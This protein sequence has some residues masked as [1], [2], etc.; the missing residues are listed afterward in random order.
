MAALALL[1]WCCHLGNAAGC[2]P[3]LR[4]LAFAMGAKRI[5]SSTLTAIMAALACTTDGLP[6]AE[7]RTQYPDAKVRN[8][9]QWKRKISSVLAQSAERI[10]LSD[11]TAA[12]LDSLV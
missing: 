8:I 3:E 2:E 11:F 10:D 4:T 9:Q 1:Q 7:V 5:E 6:L 12:E